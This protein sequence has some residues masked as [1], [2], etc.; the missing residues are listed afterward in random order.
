MVAYGATSRNRK[1]MASGPS[2]TVVGQV[3]R[4]ERT[5]GCYGDGSVHASINFP[6]VV[7]IGPCVRRGSRFVARV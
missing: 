3:S 1:P 6:S 5:M 2:L 4:V 7:H